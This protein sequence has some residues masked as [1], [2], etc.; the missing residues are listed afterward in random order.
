MPR[1]AGNP[2]VF[3]PC[4]RMRGRRRG[5]K[6]KDGKKV[7]A[8][9]AF[10]CCRYRSPI[11]GKV[12]EREGKKRKEGRSDSKIVDVQDAE[13]PELGEKKKKKKRKEERNTPEVLNDEDQGK[14]KSERP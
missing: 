3:C 5:K 7:G 9:L 4:G 10:T 11:E 14:E 12:G 1:A 2:G 6:K 8:D 13:G